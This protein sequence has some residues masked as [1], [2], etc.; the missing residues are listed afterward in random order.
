[1]EWLFEVAVLLFPL[2]V[3]AR[4]IQLDRDEMQ[5][6]WRR[7]AGLDISSGRECRASRRRRNIGGGWLARRNKCARRRPRRATV[8]ELFRPQKQI[9]GPASQILPPHRAGAG[10][11]CQPPTGAE[12][13]AKTGARQHRSRLLTPS[14]GRKRRKE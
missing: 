8:G 5:R 10:P 7:L 14:A 3:A 2:D 12:P 11:R 13:A 4:R 9:C 6:A 1:V